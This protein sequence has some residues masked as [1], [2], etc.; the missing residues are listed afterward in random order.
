[1]AQVINAVNV[2]VRVDGVVVGCLQSMDFTI[3]RDIDPT[4]CAASGIFESGSAGRARSSGTLNGV[5]REFTQAEQAANFGY[6]D[7]FD[8]LMEG[9]SVDISYGTANA[10]QR[11]YTVPALINNLQWGL[12][13]TGAVTWSAGFTGIGQP[14]YE[15][16]D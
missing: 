6:D 3:E 5:Y 14:T 10:G 4:T 7:L 13:E 12:P 9:T 1:M 11:R 16:N 2:V 15:V 8:M